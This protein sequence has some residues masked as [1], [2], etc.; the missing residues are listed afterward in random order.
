MIVLLV[1]AASAERAPDTGPALWGTNG[2]VTAVVRS[3]NTVYVGGSFTE[4]GKCTGSGIPLNR[5]TGEPEL[6]YPKVI[7]SIFAAVPDGSGGWYI[8]GRFDHVGGQLR[9]NLAHILA[10][11]EVSPWAPEP[12]T[13]VDVLV[14]RDGVV[15]A[16]GGFSTIGG[17]ERAIVA[18]LDVGTGQ[19][20]DW[21]AHAQGGFVASMV[22]RG[23][24]MF[25][26]GGFTRMGGEPCSNLAALD[27]RTAVPTWWR[28]PVLT[29]VGAGGPTVSAI[30]VDG[31]TVYV[32]GNFG[33]VDGVRRN[34]LAAVDEQTGALQAWNPAPVS[35]TVDWHVSLPPLVAAMEIRGNVLFVAGS[36]VKIGDEAREGLAAIDT[37]RGDVL[38]WSP[39]PAG[40]VSP[41]PNCFML[42]LDQDVMYVG[43]EFTSMG[44][45]QREWFAAVDARTGALLPWNP[46]PNSEVRAFA[47]SGDRIYAGGFF[48]MLGNRQKRFCLAALDATTGEA[49]AWDAHLAGYQVQALAVHGSTLYVGGDFS[50]AGG[51]G[52]ANLA[53]FD[54]ETGAPVPWSPAPSG[55]VWCLAPSD[56]VLYVGGL[57]GAIGGQERH[58]IAAVRLTDGTATDWDPNADDAVAS[59]ALGPLGVYA[60]GFFGR[61]GGQTRSHSAALDPATGAAT[62]WDPQVHS[63]G[64]VNGLAVGS[65]AVYLGGY[66][67][68]VGGE[69]RNN[70]GAVDA[71]TGSVLPWRA[72]VDDVVEAVA[73]SGGMAF[74]GGL[75]H[76]VAGVSRSGLVALD[77]ATGS[78]LDWNPMNDSAIWAMSPYEGT[79]YVGGDFASAWNEPQ[80]N[81]AAI[82]LS[83]LRA[84]AVASVSPGKEDHTFSASIEPNPSRTDAV[85]RFLPSSSGQMKLVFYDVQ[86]RQVATVVDRWNAAAEPREVRVHTAEW[87]R[88]MYFCRLE[89]PNSAVTRKLIVLK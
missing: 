85:V 67:I 71:V 5:R 6:P 8:G 9:H 54:L 46:R 56:S 65:N 10:N 86:G 52:R 31:A 37:K 29:G 60:G 74:A 49:R 41:Y 22:I 38:P 28:P 24:T 50:E 72:D 87:P 20:T 51:L 59:L 25:V 68:S 82:P 17:R 62:P 19:A 61:I 35:P 42:V 83:G 7:G 4:V 89:G 39:T 47:R 88:G 15:Y 12:N 26:G 23:G 76:S 69:P 40:W 16:G 2:T 33:W 30:E 78:V 14:V 48:T 73:V 53:A 84:A 43:G 34:G 32:G 75:F 3:G 66:F 81:V 45:Q 57:F 80:V 13:Y 27:L 21:N 36:F 77:G 11:G 63:W 70:L 79:L 44:G 55:A 1:P 64:W 18:A 58:R